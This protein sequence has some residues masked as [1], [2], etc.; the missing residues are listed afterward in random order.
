MAWSAPRV[1]PRFWIRHDRTPFDVYPCLLHRGQ[2]PCQEA[3]ARCIHHTGAGGPPTP[4]RRLRPPTPGPPPGHDTC[5]RPASDDRIPIDGYRCG[6]VQPVFCL[7]SRRWSVGFTPA[8][9]RRGATQKTLCVCDIPGPTQRW[10]A[11]NGD[12]LS[13]REILNLLRLLLIAGNETTTN[14][15]GNGVL[16]LLRHPRSA[17]AAPGR[18]GAYPVSGRRAAAV[19]TA[20]A[21]DVP[22]RPGRLRRER[23]PAAT[24]RQHRAAARRGQPRP[25]GVHGPGQAR[26]RARRICPPVV[27]ARHPPLPRGRAG[28][29]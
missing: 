2:H 24:A 21:D 3:C 22:A 1:A 25:R 15:I 11:E 16:A 28:A 29:S 10:R 17:P 12:R 20:G 13:E 27:W 9:S 7:P 6:F 23:I 8:P 14:L 19:R 26:C 5:P 4:H 18:S